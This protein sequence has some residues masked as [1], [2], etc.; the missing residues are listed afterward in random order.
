MRPCVFPSRGAP[1]RQRRRALASASREQEPAPCGPPPRLRPPALAAGTDSFSIHMWQCAPDA[2]KT[3]L[4]FQSFLRRHVLE[5]FILRILQNQ[6][7]RCLLKTKHQLMQ[8][9]TCP[10]CSALRVTASPDS[11]EWAL[12]PTSAGGGTRGPTSGG[13]TQG[14][15]SERDAGPC[16]RGFQGARASGG[17]WVSDGAEGPL[18]VPNTCPAE[19][20][21][22]DDLGRP[23]HCQ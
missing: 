18:S 20:Y 9:Q 1:S 2:M 17:L 7:V 10:L 16:G 13:W 8:E 19:T 15:T 6:T 14:Q 11:R 4:C 12:G 5:H 3:S 23:P 22:R 21:A